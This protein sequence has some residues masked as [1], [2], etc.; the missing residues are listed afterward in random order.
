MTSRRQPRKKE[1]IPRWRPNQI[2]VRRLEPGHCFY[3]GVHTDIFEVVSNEE[4]VLDNALVKGVRR[5]HLVVTIV[6]HFDPTR[7]GQRME[8]SYSPDDTVD[9]VEG[10]VSDDALPF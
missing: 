7:I 9:L 6:A 10:Q 4:L 3:G 5:R 2:S 8:F 1:Y